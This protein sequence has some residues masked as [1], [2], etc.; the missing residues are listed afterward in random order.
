MFMC[1]RKGLEVLTI[2][3]DYCD[4]VKEIQFQ[5]SYGFYTVLKEKKFSLVRFYDGNDELINT[6]ETPDLRTALEIVNKAN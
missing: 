5:D 1:L 4:N 6:V 2:S 3:L